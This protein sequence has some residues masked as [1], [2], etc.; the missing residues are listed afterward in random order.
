AERY[1]LLVI[2]HPHMG[3]VNETGC[4]VN[5]EEYISVEDLAMFSKQSVGPSFQ[6]Y[7][8]KNSLWALPVD[9][10]CQAAAYRPDLLEA[11]MLPGTWDGVV[12]LAERLAS[13]NKF[14]GVAMCATD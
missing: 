1:D 13:K 7:H 9:A 12:N 5:L 3:T 4:L 6:S 11:E 8:Y 10:A 2:D 14:I